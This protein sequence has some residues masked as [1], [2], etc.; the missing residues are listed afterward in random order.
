MA[1]KGNRGN[2]GTTQSATQPQQA[3]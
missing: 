3:C 2:G 1:K